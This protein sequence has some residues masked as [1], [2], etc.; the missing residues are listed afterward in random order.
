MTQYKPKII[1]ESP[2]VQQTTQPTTNDTNKDMQYVF[3]T[4]LAI[5]STLIIII[6]TIYIYRRTL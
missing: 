3:L 1:N 6:F 4:S 2:N 5:L